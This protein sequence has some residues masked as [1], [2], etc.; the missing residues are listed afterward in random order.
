MT[1]PLLSLVMI[2]KNEASNIKAVLEAAL[3][4]VDRATIVDTGSTDD[5]Q[6][7]VR[8]MFGGVSSKRLVVQP[9]LEFRY[10]EA[11]NFALGVDAVTHDAVFQLM[12]SGDEYLRD[13]EKLREHLEQHRDSDVDCHW[14]QLLLEGDRSYQARVL[15]TGSK[16]KYD[17]SLPMGLHE[18]VVNRDE[19]GAKTIG[20]PGAYIE[21]VV[22]DP[23][24]RFNNIWERHIPLLREHLEEHPEDERALTFLAQSYKSLF[25][26]FEER[27][28]MR[29]AFELMG[30]YLRRL[31]IPTG[32]E[33]ERN[34]IRLQYI[35]VARETAVYTPAELLRRAQELAADDPTRPEV[36]LFVARFA[37]QVLPAVKVYELAAHAAKVAEAASCIDNSL[38]V[39]VDIAWKAHHLAAA[40]AKQLARKHPEVKVKLG[41]N[42]E[43][44]YI[45]LMREHVSEGMKAGGGWEAFKNIVV[46]QE[47]AQRGA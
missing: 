31:A 18:V 34:Y 3:P 21:H 30:L 37:M 10:D 28:R 15:R 43:R 39:P 46:D 16:W 27:E 44:T 17:S 9:M 5:T 45:E 1:R 23:E 7:I 38:P 24:V 22:A 6:S 40:V 19:P 4:H 13:G 32:H 33:I 29:Y 2:V 36:A 41:D 14:M 11:R 35:D 12:L 20:V 26:F 25:P 47:P 42:P 8:E